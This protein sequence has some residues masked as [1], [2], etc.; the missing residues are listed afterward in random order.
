M[1]KRGRPSRYSEKLAAEICARIAAGE[2]LRSICEPD[3]MPAQSTVTGW[4]I[5]NVNGFYDQY[6][7]VQQMRCMRYADE[8][9]EIADDGRNDTYIDEDDNEVVRH[10]HI[11]RSAIRIDTRKF[12][13]VKFLPKIFGEKQQVALTDPNEIG[14]A[15]V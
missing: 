14:R 3:E 11:K 6:M 9:I 15:H 4:A 10:D 13:M 12:L 7:R 1:A 8:V 5:D 2:S